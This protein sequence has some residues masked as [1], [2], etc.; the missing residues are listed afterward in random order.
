MNGVVVFAMNADVVVAMVIG[1][2]RAVQVVK[3]G[4]GKMAFFGHHCQPVFAV[5]A[6]NDAVGVA[7]SS[8]PLTDEVLSPGKGDELVNLF[9]FWSV[10]DLVQC[11]L[12]PC[13]FHS[14]RENEPAGQPAY[15]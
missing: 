8:I 11:D 3:I 14:F 6:T 7:R 10:S 12:T 4:D 9:G 1:D 15:H 5:D 13:H 2:A